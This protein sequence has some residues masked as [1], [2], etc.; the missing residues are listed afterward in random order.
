MSKFILG[1]DQGRKAQFFVPYVEG[2]KVLDIGFIGDSADPHEDQQWLHR[3]IKCVARECVGLDKNK[4]KALELKA[5][6]YQVIVGDAQCFHLEDEY[7]V[8]CAFDLIEHIEDLKSF[9]NGVHAALGEKGKLLISTPNPWSFIS[10]MRCIVKGGGNL[11]KDHVG[12][13]CME[14][15]PAMLK[16]HGFKIER[17]ELGSPQPRLYIL[18]LLPKIFRHT[19]IYAVAVKS[20]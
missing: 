11:N 19:S 20:Q 10:L 16:R 5:K 12:W 8:V 17:M 14:T 4:E 2:R 9:F 1:R 13:F 3:K 6:G 15:L 7:E 18:K